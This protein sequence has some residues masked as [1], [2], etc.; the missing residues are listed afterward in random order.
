MTRWSMLR[1]LASAVFGFSLA[2]SAVAADFATADRLFSQRENNRA[3][4][5][6]ARS[7]FL[8]LLDS[9][10]N[11]N[12][13]IRA[14]EQLG[15]LALYE[16]EMLSPKSDFANRRAVFGDCWCRNAS[17]FSRTC[18]EPGWVEKISPAAIGQRVPAY[19]YYRG[20]CIGYWGEAS[21]VLE[22]AA[23]SGALR[24]T[25]NAGLDV[26]SQSAASSAY[27]GGAVHR[28]AANVWSN[29]LAR[30]VG[31]YDAKKA[32]AQIDRALAA[33][34]NGSQDP[35]SLYFDNHHTKIVVLKQL[36]SDEPSA[37]WKQKAIDFANETLLDMMDRLAQDQI[38]AS[39]AP[40]FQEIYDHI[41]ISY[42]GLTGRDWQPE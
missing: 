16:G 10:N 17:L 14:A 5:A 23:F 20:M 19:F 30:A 6:Q 38:P 42:R 8:Q 18:N 3:V 34:A 35:G 37:G 32:L 11:V 26:A 27:E 36:H 28:V 33:P 4:I 13:K 41:K 24:D 25:V 31:L 29:P 22:Q 7:E 9:A 40:E 2:H 15:R 21:T 12:D 1:A 39:R